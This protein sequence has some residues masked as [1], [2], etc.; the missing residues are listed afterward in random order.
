M[1]LRVEMITKQ[2]NMI[3]E[4]TSIK[5]ETYP[6]TDFIIPADFKEVA[7]LGKPAVGR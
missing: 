2:V 7:G 3:M 6:A 4:V 5:K 1:P